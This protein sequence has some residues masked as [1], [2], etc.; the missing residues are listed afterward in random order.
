[1]KLLIIL[2]F[3]NFYYFFII[4]LL[5]N[6]FII[7]LIYYNM[8]GYLDNFDISSSE[9]LELSENPNPWY[10]KNKSYYI[11]LLIFFIFLAV[12]VYFIYIK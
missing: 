9:G 8:N 4:K 2:L 6:N 3:N 5:I 1:M 7:H 11:Y 10:G 12:I